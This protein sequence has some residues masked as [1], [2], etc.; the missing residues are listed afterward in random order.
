MY[1]IIKL[2]SLLLAVSGLLFNSGV[3][4]AHSLES[5]NGYTAVMHNDPDDNPEAGQPAVLNFLIGKDGAS[6]NQNDYN[7][8]VDISANGKQLHH[9]VVEPEVFGNAGD[10]V[11]KYTFPSGNVYTIDLRG[12]LKTNS[13][14]K[15]HMTISVRVSGFANGRAEAVTKNNGSTVLLL[16]AGSLVVFVVGVFVIV[17]SGRRYAS[18][19]SA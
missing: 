15:F 9:G 10:G 16:S 11:A 13:S 18:K 3:A 14:T 19:K 4:E 8:S 1:K 2:A 5:N 12:S 6:Y 7:I 17:R